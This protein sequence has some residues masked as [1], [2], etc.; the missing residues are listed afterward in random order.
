MNALAIDH[1]I[2]PNSVNI[3]STVDVLDLNDP[4]KII[5]WILI[6]AKEI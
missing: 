2:D 5:D 6:N 3:P 4:D 1:T